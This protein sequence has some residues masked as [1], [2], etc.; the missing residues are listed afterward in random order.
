YPTDRAHTDAEG[1]D[2]PRASLPQ[3]RMEAAWDG[4][5]EG[6][7]AANRIGLFRAADR[8]LDV[9]RGPRMIVERLG[10]RV[11]H[12][13]EVR[14]DPLLKV[15]DLGVRDVHVA[16]DVRLESPGV[17]HD[18]AREAEEPLDA[19]PENRLP[20]GRL[21]EDVRIHDQ[22]F[23]A[24][25]VRELL[26]RNDGPVR[27]DDGQERRGRYGAVGGLHPTVER[28]SSGVP[29]PGPDSASDGPA[30]GA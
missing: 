1:R 11:E 22:D 28:E 2:S 9:C 19:V 27:V 14:A 17:R 18:R 13:P 4:A 25:P 23:R 12:G 21:T 16:V 20:V 8:F 5:D 6:Q 3:V 15:D 10:E 26:R 7:L 30:Y 29:D 24:E